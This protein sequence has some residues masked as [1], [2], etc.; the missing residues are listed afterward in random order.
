MEF[1]TNI[2]FNIKTS[3]RCPKC[4]EKFDQ[5]ADDG[6]SMRCTHCGAQLNISKESLN[7]AMREAAS[8]V[9]D[10]LESRG[11]PLPQDYAD[12]AQAKA[13]TKLLNI[14][15]IAATIW[16]FIFP[17]PYAIAISLC[18]LVPIVSLLAMVS[19]K[20]RISFETKK[21]RT[22]QPYLTFALAGPP[23]ALAWR[24]LNDFHILLFDNVWMPAIAV[25][26]LFSLLIFLF[27]ADVK[28]K[29]LYLLVTLFFGF[30]YGYGVLIEA[31]CLPD[32]S[33]PKTYTTRVL[34]K[35]TSYTS[36]S[37]SY[38]IKVAPWGP[39]TGEQEISIKKRG[40]DH[41]Q[42]NDEIGIDLKDGTLNV[43]W[44]I[45]QLK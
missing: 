39:R 29:P 9:A 10:T 24:A 1:K 28:R 4:R 22:E 8:K 21:K 20:G 32:K 19:H 15:G 31:N 26:M 12:I 36:K 30:L 41:I 18:A 33:L 40:F 11:I 3:I 37:H 35:R 25:S 16:A 2:S 17:L 14:L 23:T 7:E 13:L 43:A 42:V 45:L 27:S 44:F 34:D 5:P 38:Y 6:I